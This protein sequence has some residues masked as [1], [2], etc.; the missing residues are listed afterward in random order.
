MVKIGKTSSGRQRYKCKN[1]NKTWVSNA[2]LLVLAKLI[3]D[4]FVFRNMNYGEL[5][6]KYKMSERSI[7]R[8]MNLYT[9]PEIVPTPADVIAMDVTYSGRSWGILTVINAH[10]GK[11]L[12]SEPTNGY[13]SVW[14]YEKA[15]RKLHSYGIHP[16]V[17]IID[18]KKGVIN[19]LEKY[20]IEVQ[21]CQFHQLKIITQCLTRKPVLLPNKELRNIALSLVHTDR[22]TF[23]AM[24]Y[25]W[26]LHN[27]VWLQEKSHTEDGKWEYTHRLTRRAINS[28]ITNLPY[29][30]THQQ[31]PDLDIPNTNNKIEGLHSELKRRLNN[32]RGLKKAQKIQFARIFFSG[33][34]EA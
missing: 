30:F 18:G 19:M 6:D 29:L 2:H 13:E 21:F 22:E 4:D 5:A 34:T 24:V 15:I 26:K 1:C 28:L 32:H 17:A 31:Y 11:T 10:N 12:Y 9:P 20:G 33:R 16:K 14:D 7:R 23:I 27:E 3:W 8:K 25:G